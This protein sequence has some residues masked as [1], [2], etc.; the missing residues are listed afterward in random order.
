MQYYCNSL[1]YL[2]KKQTA[3]AKFL[4]KKKGGREMEVKTFSSVKDCLA[5][6]H[7]KIMQKIVKLLPAKTSPYNYSSWS[8]DSTRKAQ[9][10][11]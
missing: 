1:R 2:F 8:A 7:A 11:V 3:L 10:T 4:R 5:H 9:G 6:S